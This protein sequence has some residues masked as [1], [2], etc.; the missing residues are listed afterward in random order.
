MMSTRS[1]VL[2]QAVAAGVALLAA[3]FIVRLV[4]KREDASGS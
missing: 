3:T 1:I 4:E 2:L